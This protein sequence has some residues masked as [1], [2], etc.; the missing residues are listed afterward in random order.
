M[1]RA[2][3]FCLCHTREPKLCGSVDI[4]WEK[5]SDELQAVVTPQGLVG[6]SATLIREEISKHDYLP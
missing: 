5:K 2:I 3:Y 6:D 4:E 1:P